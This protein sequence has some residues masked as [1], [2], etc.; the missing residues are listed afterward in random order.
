LAN[1]EHID[2]ALFVHTKL[3]EEGAALARSISSARTTERLTRIRYLAGTVAL[4]FWLDAQEGRRQAEIVLAGN[5]LSRLQN[6]GTL[7]QALGGHR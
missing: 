5:R 3:K 2:N 4:R 6:F 7:C 1:P